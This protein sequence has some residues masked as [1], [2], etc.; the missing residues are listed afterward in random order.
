MTASYMSDHA[1]LKERIQM[2]TNDLSALASSPCG[3]PF[4]LRPAGGA[5]RGEL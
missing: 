1:R 3:M 5:F 2:S 4:V